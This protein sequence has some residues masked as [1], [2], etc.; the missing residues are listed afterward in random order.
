M[1]LALFEDSGWQRLL[2]LTW[3]RA[4][5]ELRCGCNHLLDRVREHAG[6]TLAR[7]FVR[8]ALHDVVSE[9]IKLDPAVPGQPW[10][11]VNARA[12]LTDDLPPPPVGAYW[13]LRGTCIAARVTEQELAGLTREDFLNDERLAALLRRLRPE[14]LP[15]AV[16]L[17][18]YPWDLM[19]ANDA[20]LRRQ[21][22]HGGVIAGTVYDGAHLLNRGH[23]Y[24]GP[25]ARI[26]PGVVL[27]AEDGPI[28]IEAGA[29]LQP[30]A[31]VEGPAYIGVK[32]IIRPG[33]A[34]RAGATIGP[35]CRVG[36][37]IEGSI[38]HG[39]SNKQHDGFLGHSYVASWVNLGADTVTSDLKNT[40]GTIRVAINGVGVESGQRFIGSI[41]GDH[42][43]TGIGTVLP[44]GCVI[45][46]AA[47]V[48]TQSV[49]PKFVPSFSWLT[50]DGVVQTRLDKII[51]IAR[52][53]MSR[54]E[55]DMTAADQ[56]LLEETAR[57]A[58]EVE[59]AGWQ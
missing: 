48:F 21:C 9:R 16:R 31:V 2:P 30:N 34:I 39:Q 42:A 26:K 37:E 54:R 23:I 11:L 58:R 7:V 3:L 44:T 20:E 40:Y 12:M 45:G 8:E 46:V 1:N 10:L 33:A 29:T 28:H 49:V 18:E 50:D 59:A 24:I 47:S 27:D 38:I 5:F 19:H 52:V 14:P 56:R 6:A 36:G 4:A 17:I 51:Q 57:M 22:K 41:I 53:V 55:V 43:K 35:V 15:S 13:E 25:G 32:T